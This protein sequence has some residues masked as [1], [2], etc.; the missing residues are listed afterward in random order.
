MMMLRT[1]DTCPTHR[2]HLSHGA[3][4]RA[5]GSRLIEIYDGR[6]SARVR[7]FRTRPGGAAR[8]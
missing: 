3:C 6:L 5:Q 4:Q 2:V 8:P 7:P 1:T